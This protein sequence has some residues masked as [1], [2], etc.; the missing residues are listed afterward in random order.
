[1]IRRPPRSTR[2]YTLFPYTTLFRAET[3]NSVFAVN[4]IG[5]SSIFEA[6][7]YSI[8]GTITKLDVLQA[9][10]RPQDYFCNRFHTQKSA[11]IALEFQPDDG[12]APVTIRLQRNAAGNRTVSSPSG[13]PDPEG[14]LTTL[15][16]AFALLDYRNFAR[17]IEDS[18][19]ERGRTF[20]A[21]L[22]LSA[23]SD[24]RQA[25][26]VAC[27]SRTL[28]TDLEIKVLT[29]AMA[30]AQQDRKSTRLNSSH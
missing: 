11:T 30:A 3:V 23:Y 28:N 5:K 18:P 4:G 22:G 15:R 8:F 6:I 19:L 14:F 1:M 27:D 9:Q 17:F 12:G 26:Q 13:H 7:Y 21:L 2:T 25:M 16:E 20:S 10:E 29:T 24:R